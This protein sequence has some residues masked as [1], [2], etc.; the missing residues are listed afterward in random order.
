M[1]V[2]GAA[3]V[4]FAVYAGGYGS[5]DLRTLSVLALLAGASGLLSI[6]VTHAVPNWLRHVA[7]RDAVEGSTPRLHVRPGPGRPRPVSLRSARVM[8]YVAIG[9][10]SVE[11][12]DDPDGHG[13]HR[14]WADRVAERLVAQHGDVLYA[15]LAIRGRTTRQ[16]RD[17]QLA[18][19][20]AMKPDIAVVVSG[21]NDVLRRNFD[22]HVIEED[23]YFMQRALVDAGARVITLT[24]P[25]LTPVMPL[26]RLM[27]KR[28]LALNEAIRGACR[29][30]GAIPCDLARFP[31]SSDPRLLS[32]DRLH[33]NSA[34][35]ARIADG[36]AF[37]LG[38]PGT[39]MQWAEAFPDPLR[40]TLGGIARAELAWAWRHLLPWVWRHLHGRS[41]GD[42]I[43]A[44][45]PELKLMPSASRMERQRH[46]PALAAR[47]APAGY[48]TGVAGSS[49]R[50]GRAH[51]R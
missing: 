4:V 3:A 19:A 49:G 21:T 8:R 37:C 36:V 29:R 13:G 11:G 22:R 42:G 39:S 16:V 26:A 6:A 38:L 45:R 34:G 25:D 44:K 40:P 10:S 1:I 12:L 30:S 48:E 27:R 33:A 46:N 50:R 14:G 43:T 24:V 17:E 18:R 15:N 35:H 41:S 51:A 2:F 28:V 9:D 5:P 23:L 32:P 47:P 20:V 31:V 7:G